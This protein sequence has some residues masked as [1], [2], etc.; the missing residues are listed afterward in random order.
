MR[1]ALTG[2][3]NHARCS[4]R[5]G[6]NLRA[7]SLLV[8]V[9]ACAARQKP[10]PAVQTNP[11]GERL[12][13][14]IDVAYANLANALSDWQ[15]A[16]YGQDCVLVFN[17]TEEWLVGCPEMA[18]TSG[19]VASSERWRE[20]AVLWNPRSFVLSDKFVPYDQV[21][22]GLVGRIGNYTKESKGERVE[23]PVLML[24]E[25]DALHKNHPGFQQSNIEEWLGIFVHEAFHGHQLFHPRVRAVV[26]AM[27]SG[28]ALAAPEELAAFYKQNEAFQKAV[29]AE[30]DALRGAADDPKLDAARAKQALS[31][32]L[33][34]YRARQ[35]SF[36]P[37]L[38][39]ALPGK[40]AWAM[41]GFETFLEG[42]ARYVEARFLIAPNEAAFGALASEP[43][44]RQFAASKGK[45]P[46]ELE[47]LGNLG[48]KY[49]YSLGMYVC[50][51][52]DVADPAW[53]STLFESDGLL[54][55]QVERST[56]RR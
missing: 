41:D 12:R 48:S 26:K 40:Q 47:G 33:S 5:R 4:R 38:E 13:A 45:R 8:A 50:L 19:F 56:S 16:N 44:F 25:W 3:P 22:L 21:K 7:V 17:E 18:G 34:L 15:L 20:G 43:T 30:Y 49:F 32:W 35:Q 27:S 54:I 9:C 31:S 42:T 23:R 36:E 28:K 53:K 51:L 1:E 24:Q 29:R 10:V 39:Q 52:L 55:A 6:M 14:R 11:L 2:L 46:S 37:A